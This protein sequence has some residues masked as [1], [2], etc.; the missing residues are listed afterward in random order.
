[1]IKYNT[2]A[3][4]YLEADLKN[5]LRG[6]CFLKLHQLNKYYWGGRYMKKFISLML[7]F[8]LTSSL[9]VGCSN[10]EEDNKDE[11]KDVK[12]VTVNVGAPEGLPAIAIAK[13]A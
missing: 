13:L 6:N 8:L 4:I 5:Y 2:Y 7:S 1:M 12:K 10:T 3:K 9:V 11:A